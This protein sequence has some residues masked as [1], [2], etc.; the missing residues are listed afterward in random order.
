[1]LILLV[2]GCALQE[3]HI[4][5]EKETPLTVYDLREVE[6]REYKGNKLDSIVDVRDLSI[7][8]PQRVDINNYKL[9]VSGLVENP[10]NYTYDQVLD[11]QKYRKAI[12]IHCVTGWSAEVL[13]EG[14]LL[15][16]LFD[17]V[18]VKPEANTVIFYAA[19]G[20]T[21]SLPLSFIIE[22]NIMLADKINNATLIPARGFPFQLVA[23]D[24][25][26]YKWIKWVTK[27]ELSDNPDYEGYWESRGYSNEADVE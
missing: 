16:D 23:E 24:K 14:V 25:L 8:G 9:E 6:V 4:P 3:K 12:F 1:M 5:E 10:K 27:I 20:Y 26:G 21:T 15:N 11:H 2:S 17:E 7:K 18:D 22:N 19:D 13:W